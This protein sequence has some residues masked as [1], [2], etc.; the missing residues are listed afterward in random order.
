LEGFFC[1]RQ[2]EVGNEKELYRKEQSSGEVA[3]MGQQFMLEK[4]SSI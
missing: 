4:M 1:N 2:K 3:K